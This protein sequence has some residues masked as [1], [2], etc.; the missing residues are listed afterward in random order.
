MIDTVIQSVHTVNIE[1]T[2][3]TEHFL[4]ENTLLIAL[5]L[6]DIGKSLCY[7]LGISYVLD[8]EI[9]RSLISRYEND[10]TYTEDLL[11]ERS[12]MLD[13]EYSVK[14]QLIIYVV[15]KTCLYIEL[16]LVETVSR[17]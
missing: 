13:I 8:L 15:E 2:G 5:L 14:E 11:E 1:C 9:G 12:L 16:I 10:R 7:S 6:D 17:K 3:C 4:T